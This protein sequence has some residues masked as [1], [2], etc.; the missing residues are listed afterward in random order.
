MKKR[1]NDTDRKEGRKGKEPEE[2]RRETN[3]ET[4]NGRLMMFFD[5]DISLRFHSETWRDRPKLI[6]SLPQFPVDGF[7]LSSCAPVIYMH[8]H[9]YAEER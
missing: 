3:M 6:R 5:F 9:R 2:K 1:Y 8:T 4:D 7:V